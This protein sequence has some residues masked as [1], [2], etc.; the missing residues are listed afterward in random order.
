M[1]LRTNIDNYNER[2]FRLQF[3]AS[4]EIEHKLTKGQLREKFLKK[5]FISELEELN[6]K[7]GILVIDEWQSSQGDFL[8]LKRGARVGLMNV[9]DIEDCVLFMEIKSRVTKAEFRELQKHALELKGKNP[10]MTVGMFSYASKAGRK[11]VIP[12]FGF[13]YDRTLEMFQTYDETKDEYS[14]IDFYYNLDICMDDNEES[15]Y[16][17]RKSASGEKIL[18]LQPPVIGNLVNLFRGMLG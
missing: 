7:D 11:T 18:F 17:I 1:D 10:D 6:V 3:E 15:P 4:E 8:I 13:K 16:F 12:Q 5:F 14:A 2:M 9:Y